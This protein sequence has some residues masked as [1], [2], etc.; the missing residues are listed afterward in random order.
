[1][2]GA[3]KKRGR[4]TEV[5]MRRVVKRA[6]SLELRPPTVTTTGTSGEAPV[7]AA[8]ATTV[9][10]VGADA[11]TRAGVSPKAMAYRGS[12]VKQ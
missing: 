7:A 3:A 1:M 8:G 10:S 11:R 6:L 5:V 12:K 4:K 9:S 2:T